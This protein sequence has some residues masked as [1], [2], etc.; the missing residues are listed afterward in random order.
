MPYLFVIWRLFKTQRLFH[1]ARYFILI[2]FLLQAGLLFCMEP[3]DSLFIVSGISISGNKITKEKIILKELTFT[4]G[5]ILSPKK[6]T[7]SCQRSRENLLNTALFN[8]VN[9]SHVESEGAGTKVYI[10]VI[11]RWYIWPAPIFEHAERNLGAFIHNPDWNRINYGGQIFW[12]NFRGRREQLKLKA[13]FGYKEQLEFLYEKPNFGKNQKHGINFTLN[14]TRQHEVNV[15]SENNKPVYI[16]NENSYLAEVF[17]PYF[18]YSYRNSLYSIHSL[19]LS[20]L[21][22]TFRD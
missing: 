5:D 3:G 18:I 2:F 20:F 14:Q 1:I 4:T 6:L 15:F 22:L 13:R 9:I 19:L 21:G 10:S 7:E 11:E 12:Y 16:R 8:F 17:N